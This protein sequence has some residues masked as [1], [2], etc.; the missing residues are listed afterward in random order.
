[1]SKEIS[2]ITLK[3]GKEKQP[4]N[5]HPWVFSGAIASPRQSDINKEG[6]LVKVL[7]HKNNF[8]AYGWCDIN[9]HI[10]IHLLSWDI[11]IVP[12]TSWWEMQIAQAVLRRKEMIT[13]H[14]NTTNAYRLI[15]GEADFLPGVIVD[16]YANTVVVLLSARVAL[17]HEL[18]I[19]NVLEK[20][21]SPFYIYVSFDSSF[22]HA[23]HSPE[24]THIYK[25]GQRVESEEEI[26]QVSTFLE[27]S[28][29][30]ILDVKGQKSGFFCDQRDNRS[31]VSS[32]TKG[33][34]VLDTFCYSGAFTI[35]AL[36]EGASSITSVDSSA[37]ALSY[38]E[39]NI[40]LN[41]HMEKLPKDSHL[42]VHTVK[43]NV[44]E[45]LREIKEDEYDV[46]ILDP[47]KLAATKSQVPQA[48]KAYK[49]LNRLA[50][51]K[52]KRG[53]I[54]ASFSCSAG[55]S[56]N[57][58]QT[59]IAWAAKDARKE[60]HIKAILS[61]GADHPIRLSFPESHY[62]TGFLLFVL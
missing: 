46:I 24:F 44:F 23:E 22:V 56:H 54:V 53:G 16:L 14:R 62:L 40:A 47:P 28:Y 13:N 48:L 32:Y 31:I 12:D 17:F 18:T 50:I 55:V 6:H 27:N 61:Q 34:K 2:T 49:D 58:L 30:Y 25:D 7:D 43:A 11:H 1:M 3:M 39:K 10:M 36:G 20:L 41:V 45:Y 52:V 8:I 42:K 29:L 33:K 19:V 57:D 35:N 4:M 37:R 59:A 26:S 38:L 5:H 60:V 51:S 9:S 15:H 21:L